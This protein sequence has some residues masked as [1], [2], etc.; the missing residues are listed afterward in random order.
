VAETIT[1]EEYQRSLIA[2]AR[3]DAFIAKRTRAKKEDRPGSLLANQ[4]E[5]DYRRYEAQRDA[6]AELSRLL[7]WRDHLKAQIQSHRRVYEDLLGRNRRNLEK[8]EEELARRAMEGR[9]KNSD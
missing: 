1:E 4:I 2:D 8:V 3:N 9:T 7:E 5:E 6:E